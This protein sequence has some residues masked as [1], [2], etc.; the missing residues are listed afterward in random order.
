MVD[1]L[2][3]FFGIFCQ[4]FPTWLLDLLVITHSEVMSILQNFAEGLLG[5]LHPFLQLSRETHRSW[6]SFFLSLISMFIRYFYFSKLMNTFQVLLPHLCQKL[7]CQMS[8]SCVFLWYCWSS[9]VFPLVVA[10]ILSQSCLQ[11]LRGGWWA[12]WHGVDAVLF[13]GFQLPGESWLA[14][15]WVTCHCSV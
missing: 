15:S 14:I 11:G 8:D 4:T 12:P 13:D 2:L 6:F 3:H 7:A 9:S 5:S 10:V 1:K